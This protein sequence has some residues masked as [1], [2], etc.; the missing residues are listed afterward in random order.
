MSNSFGVHV[1]QLKYYSKCFTSL[2]T[3]FVYVQSKVIYI[4]NIYKLCFVLSWCNC[5]R[6]D[7]F[8]LRKVDTFR[9]NA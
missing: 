5:C 1:A 6:N 9:T 4:Y 2:Q 8:F 3:W 7:A